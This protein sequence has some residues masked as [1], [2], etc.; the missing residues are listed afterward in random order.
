MLRLCTHQVSLRLTTGKANN[1]DTFHPRCEHNTGNLTTSVL[2]LPESRSFVQASQFSGSCK[3][4]LGPCLHPSI[5]RGGFIFKIWHVRGHRISSCFCFVFSPLF[6]FFLS[7]L[8][9]VS[10][11]SLCVICIFFFLKESI[12][13]IHRQKKL[14][15]AMEEEGLPDEEV[16]YALYF[17]YIIPTFLFSFL[18]LFTNLFSLQK[19]MRRSQHARKETEFLRLKRTRLGL[20]DFESLK[21]IGRGAFGEVHLN[22]K[23]KQN[24]SLQDCG[25]V[26]K[27]VSL[28]DFDW[29][30]VP[31]VRLV[32]KKD[33]GH[34]Y[35]MKILRKADMLEKEQ[36]MRLPAS[37]FSRIISHT[38]SAAF[39]I[40]Y[41]RSPRRS[42]TSGQRGIFWL[43]QMV[44]GW[45]RC[46]TASRT[47]ETS[48]SLWSSC[49]E[50][51]TGKIHRPSQV[52]W[53]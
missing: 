41:L 6:S 34:I 37:Q 52:T 39:R 27:K 42:L 49:L 29:C 25:T 2:T 11:G 13:F 5:N 36:V 16:Q 26:I 40:L 28:C 22:K 47:R 12:V 38:C 44:P 19:V 15:K 8:I 51:S 31:Q 3:R 4:R 32:Q 30:C 10:W 35:A 1:A 20:D 50:V 23:L 45:S 46:S 7:A 43:R 48:T 21:V 18:D 53:C 17:S 9:C 33:T 24:S 14:E